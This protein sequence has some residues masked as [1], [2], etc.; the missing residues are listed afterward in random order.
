MSMTAIPS[1]ASVNATLS[2]DD[3]KRLARTA[4][5]L[6]LLSLIGGG[7]GEFYAP[8]T[9]FVPGN[10]AATA[11]NVHEM[12]LLFRLG[13]AGY[14]IEATCDVAL[15]WLFYLLL[16]P[17]NRNLALLSAFFGLI[18]TATFASSEVFYFLPTYILGGSGYLQAFSP[19]QLNALALLSFRI[20]GSGAGLL[21]V[22]YGMG[23][24][25][26]G[27]LMYQSSYFPKAVGA[28][29]TLAGAGFIVNNFALVLLPS[30]TTI[31]FVVP[32]FV[33]GVALT[34][35]LFASGVDVKKWNER[36]GVVAA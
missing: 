21:M 5:F 32:M 33:G 15:A 9:I 10:A 14:L 34:I 17:V 4:G 27:Y 29:M 19:D 1:R 35:W 30:A 13:F 12:D 36:V 24:V 22:F 25:I 16:K 31:L 18:A 28:I 8:S 6:F 11:K 7:L 2:G 26:R 20:Y 23:W 3:A